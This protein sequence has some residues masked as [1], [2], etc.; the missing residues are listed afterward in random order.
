[1][2]DDAINIAKQHAEKST[3]N[4]HYEKIRVEDFAAQNPGVFDVITCMEML[5]HVP[6][7]F[8]IIQAATQLLKPNGMIFFS[9]INRNMTSF[10]SA[11]VGAEYVLNLLPKGT[12]HY[13]KFIKPSELTQWAEKNKLVLR[14][15]QGITY[16]PFKNQFELT[17]SIDVNYMASFLLD[18][19][20]T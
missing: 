2:S 3:L 12:H 14:G 6:D 8:A 13:Q 1:M 5:E 7:P 18:K 16:H 10:L 4:I 17:N 19:I 9:T 15:L 11:I 20:V